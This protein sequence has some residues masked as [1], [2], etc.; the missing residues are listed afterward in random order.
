MLEEN[1]H[2]WTKEGALQYIFHHITVLWLALVVNSGH[3][4]FS[5]SSLETGVSQWS[6]FQSLCKCDEVKH[7]IKL[8]KIN[9]LEIHIVA[10]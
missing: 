2:L 10:D 1:S 8:Y 7:Y 5:I 6:K 4:N 3:R 9:F